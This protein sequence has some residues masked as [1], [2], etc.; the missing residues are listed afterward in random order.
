MRSLV[1]LVL[2]VVFAV[3]VAVIAVSGNARVSV[4]EAGNANGVFAHRIVIGGLASVTGPL[5]AE[6][7]PVFDGVTAYVD[8]TNAQGGVNG[9]RI[10][11]AYPLDD[12]SDPLVDVEQAQ[13][14]VNQYHVFAVVG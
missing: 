1:V 9:R 12:Q 6:F 10:D 5:P 8:M 4:T 14:L 3:L 13:S 7:A 2:L 11:F